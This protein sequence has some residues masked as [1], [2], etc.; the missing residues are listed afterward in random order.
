MTPGR[1]AEGADRS[2]REALQGV[3]FGRSDQDH[4]TRIVRV[5]P[6]VWKGCREGVAEVRCGLSN[7]CCHPGPT[8]EEAGMEAPRVPTWGPIP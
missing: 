3:S 8:Y 1:V 4:P 7:P 5:E 2:P 6:A